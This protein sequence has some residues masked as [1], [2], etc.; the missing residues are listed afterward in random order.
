MAFGNFLNLTGLVSIDFEEG[1]N[2]LNVFLDNVSKAVDKI[3]KSFDGIDTKGFSNRIVDIGLNFGTMLVA[4]D[5]AKDGMMSGFAE[6]RKAGGEAFDYIGSRAKNIAQ[7]AIHA[8]SEME[9]FTRTLNVHLKDTAKTAEV[10]KR[11]VDWEITSPWEMSDVQRATRKFVARGISD[12]DEVMKYVKLASEMAS[13][14]DQ[15]IGKAADALMKI[16]AR[17]PEAYRS[18]KQNFTIGPDQLKMMGVTLDSG[19]RLRMRTQGDA[20]AII[21]ALQG[22]YEKTTGMNASAQQAQTIMGKWSSLESEIWRTS[23]AFADIIAPKLKVLI[24][25]VRELIKSLNNL[26]PSTKN[27]IANFVAISAAAFTLAGILAPIITIVG[28]FVAGLG[29]LAIALTATIIGFVSLT[30]VITGLGGLP[31]ILN[32]I[33]S[34]LA[35][36]AARS[37]AGAAGV[38]AIGAA[39]TGAS[40]KFSAW[41]AAISTLSDKLSKLNTAT[42]DDLLLTKGAVDRKAPTRIPTPV[43]GG[44]NLSGWRSRVE[45]DKWFNAATA[46]GMDLKYAVDVLDADGNPISPRPPSIPGAVAGGRNMPGWRG[47]VVPVPDNLLSP[48]QQLSSRWRDKMVDSPP[49]EAE[50]IRSWKQRGIESGSILGDLKQPD[51]SPVAAVGTNWGALGIIALVS[52]VIAV[53]GTLILNWAHDNSARVGKDLEDESRITQHQLS[54]DK[55]MKLIK[56]GKSLSDNEMNALEKDLE[57]QIKDTKE[58]ESLLLRNSKKSRMA[59]QSIPAS[60]FDHRG[61]MRGGV[62]RG[63]TPG[64]EL[65]NV[66]TVGPNER[67]NLFW[68]IKKGGLIPD[69]PSKDY[70]EKRN[71]YGVGTAMGAGA[72]L[73]TSP[74]IAA[75]LQLEEF[76]KLKEKKAEE[77]KD[78]LEMTE[79]II[80]D[81]KRLTRETHMGLVSKEEAV[82]RWLDMK[83]RSIAAGMSADDVAKVSEQVR[84]AQIAAMH[85][86]MYTKVDKLRSMDSAK[87]QLSF[88]K[89]DEYYKKELEIIDKTT[90]S[91]EQYTANK[92]KQAKAMDDQMKYIAQETMAGRFMNAAK[93]TADLSKIATW[94]PTGGN[95]VRTAEDEKA[96]TAIMVARQQNETAL[97][98]N[99]R[100]MEAEDLAATGH[101]LESKILLAKIHYREQLAVVGHHNKQALQAQRE[102][103]IAIQNLRLEDKIA[104]QKIEDEKAAYKREVDKH[105]IARSQTLFD[106]NMS[107]GERDATKQD[108]LREKGKKAAISDAQKTAEEQIRI[109]DA[110]LNNKRGMEE[111]ERKKLEADKLK[112]QTGLREAIKDINQAS[113]ITKQQQK[114]VRTKEDLEAQYGTASNKSATLEYR[115]KLL[116]Q[117]MSAAK[118]VDKVDQVGKTME[119]NLKDQYETQLNMINLKEKED[120]LNKTDAQI[121]VI[122]KNAELERLNLQE[123]FL[124]K[125][126]DVTAEMEKQKALLDK[127]KQSGFTMGGIYNSYEEIVKHDMETSTK[128]QSQYEDST[129][130]STDPDAARARAAGKLGIPAGSVSKEVLIEKTRPSLDMGNMGVGLDARIHDRIPLRGSAGYNAATSARALDAWGTFPVTPP[131][132]LNYSARANFGSGGEG[133]QIIVPVTV[134]IGDKTYNQT[135]TQKLT[136]SQMQNPMNYKHPKGGL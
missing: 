118:S 127:G 71:V 51:P 81:E 98:K 103:N 55:R 76:K 8:S 102:L 112:I 101:S 109:I 72:M 133:G 13:V 31:N 128:F 30:K 54:I 39:A 35:G 86:E 49:T 40:T 29:S 65:E 96:R 66:G 25:W 126:Q 11:A 42:F 61:V 114:D 104:F 34:G 80:Q 33:A 89:K 82:T 73:P 26:S 48:S 20:Q 43:P 122:Q 23:A 99:S 12:P 75:K 94:D 105:A 5:L 70:N 69:L 79:K 58:H 121:K 113:E 57:A 46:A 106:F 123:K 90:I 6:L 28:G 134:N 136:G 120:S 62:M 38:T 83:K 135:Q 15:D 67:N 115:E 119:K 36:I 87:E 68:N 95:A 32:T 59:N 56:S 63:V 27:I 91:Y 45:A 52:T 77:V 50:K 88:A 74:D 92:A 131:G 41:G 93:G 1:L 9:T 116:S 47:K 44:R 84:T 19:D 117:R 3:E 21:D 85:Q 4:F 53:A 10:A 130:A 18:L 60:E 107:R 97:F 129:A 100:K 108:D 22:Y 37:A 110:Q 111:K 24:D 17:S 125:M 124:Q 78:H 2:Q 64:V 132:A 16:R 14:N 7:D